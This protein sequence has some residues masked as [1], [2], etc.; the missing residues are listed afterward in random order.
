MNVVDCY[1]K[2]EVAWHAY[3]HPPG[4]LGLSHLLPSPHPHFSFLPLVSQSH[5]QVPSTNLF[6][7]PMVHPLPVLECGFS[8]FL[9]LS[10]HWSVKFTIKSHLLVGDPVI[11]IL[12]VLEC[13]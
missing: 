6:G 1:S 7:E 3:S 12:L 4:M 9:L 5:Q 2:M 8:F 13:D 11:H 10:C